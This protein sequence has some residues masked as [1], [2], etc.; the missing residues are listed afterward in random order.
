MEGRRDHSPE[1]ASSAEMVALDA[2]AIA[3]PG[4]WA[5]ILDLGAITPRPGRQR[6]PQAVATSGRMAFGSRDIGSVN[7]LSRRH[8]VDGF[9]HAQHREMPRD[10][11]RGEASKAAF[12]PSVSIFV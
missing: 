2:I 9:D 8:L 4:P 6:A 5:A 12:G 1:W 11:A 3:L 7:H 10:A